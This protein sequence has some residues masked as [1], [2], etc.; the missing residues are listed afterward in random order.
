[1]ILCPPGQR[2]PEP[3][4]DLRSRGVQQERV[5][6]RQQ[7]A[8]GRVHRGS[9]GG[10]RHLAHLQRLRHQRKRRL[11]RRGRPADQEVFYV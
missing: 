9:P 4:H 5:R 6:P 2:H 1:M 10:R 11:R 7:H 8:G 3:E